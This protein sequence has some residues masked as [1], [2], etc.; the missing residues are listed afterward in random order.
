MNET[1]PFRP[2]LIQ[3]CMLRKPAAEVTGFD[4]AF[5]CDYMGSAEFEFGSLPA[6]LRRVVMRT[7]TARP[8]GLSKDG[9]D[10][11]LVC[12]SDAQHDQVKAWL[13]LL[14]ANKAR[15]KEPSF[16]RQVLADDGEYQRDIVLWWDISNDWFLCLNQD[17]ADLLLRA[18]D[19]L[20]KKWNTKGAK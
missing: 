8:S 14:A 20:A 1:R 3:R 17:V 15:L 5:A 13:P 10:L 7:Y 16:L 4:S 18:I 19:A 6:S 9:K 12:H 11:M 2:W